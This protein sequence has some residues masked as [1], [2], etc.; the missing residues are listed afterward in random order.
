MVIKMNIG[1]RINRCYL[2]VAKVSGDHHDLSLQKLAE[3]QSFSVQ[4][5]NYAIKVGMDIDVYLTGRKDW[6]EF[7]DAISIAF[8]EKIQNDM[9]TAF[10]EADNKLPAQDKFVITDDLTKENKSKFDD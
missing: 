7:V 3:G 9:F 6:S 1:L 10:V 8:Q 2:T 4:T 5:S